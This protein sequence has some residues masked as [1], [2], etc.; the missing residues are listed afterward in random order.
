MYSGQYLQ[1]RARI[2][3]LKSSTFL[4]SYLLGGDPPGTSSYSDEN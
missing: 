3:Q 4:R 2:L 1:Y